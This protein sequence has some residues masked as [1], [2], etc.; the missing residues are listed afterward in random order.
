MTWPIEFTVGE[1]AGESRAELT[2]AGLCPDCGEEGGNHSA[3][4]PTWTD[5][6][7]FEV[8]GWLVYDEGADRLEDLR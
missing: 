1:W 3:D 5:D 8:V 6:P 4:C 2:D 7:M